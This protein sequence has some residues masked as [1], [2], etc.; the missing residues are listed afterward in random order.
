[1]DPAY[2]WHR[3]NTTTSQD[4]KIAAVFKAASDKES[5][6]LVDNNCSGVT[7]RAYSAADH[8]IS[9]WLTTVPGATEF[10]LN[11]AGYPGR[12]TAP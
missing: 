6:N 7:L 4:A 5:F 3:V 9:Q 10:Q 11:L 2:D 12:A 1:M 8:P